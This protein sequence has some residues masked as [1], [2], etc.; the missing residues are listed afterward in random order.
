MPV[1]IRR[2]YNECDINEYSRPEIPFSSE[3]AELNSM[4]CFSTFDRGM[5][6]GQSE[7]NLC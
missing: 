7:E 4:F 2:W 3:P 6:A 5:G 1:D